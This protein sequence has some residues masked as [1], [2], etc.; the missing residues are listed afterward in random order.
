MVFLK[1]SVMV[2]ANRYLFGQAALERGSGHF[3]A[4]IASDCGWGPSQCLGVHRQLG[5]GRVSL[6]SHRIVRVREL[7]SL[8]V[9]IWSC[10]SAVGRSASME[11]HRGSR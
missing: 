5:R 2:G 7:G 10:L 4:S 8:L 6:Y 9:G 1:I 11:N 3:E